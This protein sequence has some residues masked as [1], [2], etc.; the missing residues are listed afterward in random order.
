MTEQQWLASSDP[1][2]MLGFLGARVSERKR[3]LFACACARR[4]WE[5]LSREGQKAVRVAEKYADGLIGAEELRRAHRRSG[6]SRRSP[7]WRCLMGHDEELEAT[8]ANS[9]A[10][11]SVW[12]TVNYARSPCVSPYVYQGRLWV[13]FRR[14]DVAK[15]DKNWER[16]WEARVTRDC[17]DAWW[18]ERRAQAD[19]LRCIFGNPFRP[20][21]LLASWLT[22]GEGTVPK[23]A[24]AIHDERGEQL[25]GVLADALEDA[26]CT[27]EVLLG[28][29]RGPDPHAH[30]CWA[31]DLL[32]RKE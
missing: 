20:A 22:W 28:H 9:A 11:Q 14:G 7:W 8:A 32:L 10:W 24:K 3:R 26:G 12:E 25:L 30:G 19:L 16:R 5:F 15:E 6:T 2:E 27:E 29:L 21:L 17:E 1:D 23:L 13:R 31:I 18:S 4:V